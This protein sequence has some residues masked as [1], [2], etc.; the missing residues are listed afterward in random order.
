MAYCVTDG[1]KWFQS[2]LE[3]M[4]LQILQKVIYFKSFTCHVDFNLLKVIHDMF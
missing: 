1:I 2:H 4:V 3:H